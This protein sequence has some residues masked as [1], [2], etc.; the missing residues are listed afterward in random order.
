MVRDFKIVNRGGERVH[1]FTVTALFDQN[2]FG[3]R[4]FKPFA[5]TR[6]SKFY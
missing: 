3:I 2:Q 5:V 1:G 6:K 4:L